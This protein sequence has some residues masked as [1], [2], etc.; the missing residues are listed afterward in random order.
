MACTK[1]PGMALKVVENS[2]AAACHPG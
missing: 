2:Q 1:S